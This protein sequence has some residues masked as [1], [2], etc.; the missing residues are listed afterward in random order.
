MVIQFA[1]VGALQGLA[2][3]AGQ[4]GIGE[5]Q[6]HG[7]ILLFVDGDQALERML[8]LLA[9]DVMPDELLDLL[10]VPGQECAA[11][12]QIPG[13]IMRLDALAGG[14]SM[15][16]GSGGRRFRRRLWSAG[17]PGYR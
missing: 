11:E 16:L 14:A 4:V 8:G 9:L 10:A 6:F 17:K 2:H 12:A 3:T 7:A 15:R 13:G 1:V 5:R